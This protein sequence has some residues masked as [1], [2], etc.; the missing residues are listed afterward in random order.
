[1]SSRFKNR[2]G[3]KY[4]RLTFVRPTSID[5]TSGDM[6]WIVRCDCGKESELRATVV[7]RGK[8]KSC[9]CIA[10]DILRANA[11]KRIGVPLKH[12]H[13][14]NGKRTSE[15]SIY[16]TMK[17]RCY[18]KNSK[19]Y[20]RYGGRGI[21]VCDRWLESF[22]NFYADMGSRP[23]SLHSIDRVNNDGPYS[24]DNCRWA[25]KKEQSDNSTNPIVIEFNGVSMNLTGWAKSI[26]INLSS[27]TERIGK[28]GIERALTT[29]RG[30]KRD[31]RSIRA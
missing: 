8:T 14:T 29:P 15:Y 7:V 25:T 21:A 26:G 9:G 10:I 2:V 22:D 6:R 20:I 11:K 23:S 28:W 4:N 16:K 12:G 18:N 13:S 30:A 19:N 24:P 27:L 31:T 17:A 3:E 1:M 5:T